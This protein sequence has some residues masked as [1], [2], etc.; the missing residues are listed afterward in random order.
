MPSL[1]TRLR[2]TARSCSSPPRPRSP[3]H[4]ASSSQAGRTLPAAST[5]S[6]YPVPAPPRGRT[7]P[8]GPAPCGSR[9]A[10]CR[11]RLADSGSRCGKDH[12]CRTVRTRRRSRM[13]GA[14]TSVDWRACFSLMSDMSTLPGRESGRLE[15]AAAAGLG[16]HRV[17]GRVVV[18]PAAGVRHVVRAAAARHAGGHVDQLEA[19][20]PVDG[21]GR[22][23]RARRLPGPEA[24]PADLDVGVV[25]GQQRDRIAVGG[26]DVAVPVGADE[27]HLDA[28]DRRVDVAGGAARGGLLAQHVPRLD[29]AAQLDLDAVEHRGADAREP[30]LGERVQPAGVEVDAV[31]PQVG[32]DVGDVVNQEVRQQVSAVQVGA[33]ADRAGR[34]A[35]R[36]RTMPPAS[37]PAATAPSPSGSAAASRSRAA[38]A[39]RA[40]HGRCRGCTACRC[41]TRPGGCCR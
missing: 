21:D 12:H 29:R 30:E 8:A 32:G 2:T 4:S 36:P 5:N 31:R 15:A 41:R 9:P 35:A 19:Q 18:G 22:V 17:D 10:G 34:A 39:G 40:C 16:L 23:Q 33:V 37:A 11:C 6:S 3:T 20:R 24:H 14:P 27:P 25:G 28:L 7:A 26:D 1:S 38:P 13:P